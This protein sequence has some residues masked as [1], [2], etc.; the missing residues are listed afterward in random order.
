MT[1]KENLVSE[2]K[3][4]DSKILQLVNLIESPE[5]ESL[6][7]SEVAACRLQLYYMQLYKDQLS[8]R[9]SIQALRQYVPLTFY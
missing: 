5:F 6:A 4:L 8:I 2:L 7:A 1:T 9:I 3:D